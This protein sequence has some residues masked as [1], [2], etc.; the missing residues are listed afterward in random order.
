MS[1]EWFLFDGKT[2]HGP[3][4][5]GELT[6]RLKAFRNLDNVSVLRPGFRDWEPAGQ[7]FEL[8]RPERQVGPDEAPK[9]SYKRRYGLYGVYGGLGVC[10]GDMVLKWRGEKFEAWQGDGIAHN[11]GYIAGTVGMLWFGCVLV[12]FFRDGWNSKKPSDSVLDSR[13]FSKVELQPELPKKPSRYHNFVAQNWRG[14]YSLVT[15]YWGFGF[16]G[17]ILAGLVPIIAA[18]AFQSKGGYDPRAILATMVAIWAGLLAIVTW[19][20]VGVWR[21]ANRYIA[22]RVILGKRSP[23][24]GLAKVAVFLGLLRLVGTFVS[25]GLPQLAETSRM[26]FLDDPDIPAYSIRVMRN[27]TEAEITGGFKYGLTDDFVKILNAS[28]QIGVVHLDSLGGRIGEAIKLNSL[29]RQRKLDTYVSANCLS[30]C[31]VAFAGGRKRVLRNGAKLGFHAPAF[32]GTSA[33]ELAEAAKDQKDIFAAAGFNEA[34]VD[35][36][37]STPSSELW[38]PSADVLLQAGAITASSDGSEY[39]VSGFGANPTK[40][41]IGD[42]LTKWLPVL[43]ALRVRFPDEYDGV[44][45]AYYDSFVSGQTEDEAALAVRAKLVVT[46]ATLRPLADDAVLVDVGNVYADQYSALGAKN[47]ALCYQYAS[48]IGNRVTASDIPSELVKRENEIN[49]RVVETAAKRPVTPES[50]SNAL[51]KKIG[52]QLGAKGVATEQLDL[53]GSGS[54][55]PGRYAEYCTVAV[56]LYRE[57]GKLPQKEAGTLLRQL[58]SEK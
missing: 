5:H 9:I 29:I 55:S 57:I 47:P 25:T 12:G 3:L 58:L 15:S 7:V 20:L 31:T 13:N 8:A 42:Q 48:G 6:D 54:V 10:L 35:R 22:A 50:L 11:L 32:P 52:T 28:R 24:A 19:Q 18:V 30:A 37:L 40:Q 41:H 2:E 27:G 1:G 38:E 44:V 23:W 17:N 49:K 46:F 53:I 16:L 51:W 33:S 21:S 39:A 45:Q 26:A 4:A 43:Q 34:F 14:E 36:A 56:L